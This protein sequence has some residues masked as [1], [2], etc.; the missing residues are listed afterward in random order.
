MNNL[1]IVIII[2]CVLFLVIVFF[3]NWSWGSFNKKAPLCSG[4]GLRPAEYLI[5]PEVRPHTVVVQLSKHMLYKHIFLAHICTFAANISVCID[6]DRHIK[7]KTTFLI[8]RKF[9]SSSIGLDKKQ[10]L[11][12]YWYQFQS[13]SFSYFMLLIIRL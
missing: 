7:L 9:G 10:S 8:I 5:V 13:F 1:S 3:S 6:R 4:L 12:W 2:S 11:R